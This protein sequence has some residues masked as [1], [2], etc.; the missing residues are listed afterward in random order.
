MH[1]GV[2]CCEEPFVVGVADPPL[3]GVAQFSV[4]ADCE[5]EAKRF[6]WIE[7]EKAGRDLGDQAEYQWFRQH[8]CGYLRAKWLEHLQGKNY[9]KELDRNDFGLLKRE[10]R[11]DP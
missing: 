7:S 4:Y 6:K 5:A 3:D 9:W 10:F 8:W 2:Q 11:S 1:N